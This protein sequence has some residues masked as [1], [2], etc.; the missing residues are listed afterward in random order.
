[1]P[2]RYAARPPKVADLRQASDTADDGAEVEAPPADNVAEAP[3]SAQ[4]VLEESLEPPKRK[5]GR[6]RKNP[7]A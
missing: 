1:M 3:E 5:R 4:E 2:Y 7:D 6:P